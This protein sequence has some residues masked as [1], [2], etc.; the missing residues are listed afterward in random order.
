MLQIAFIPLWEGRGKEVI[1][2]RS[3][4]YGIYH[5]PLSKRKSME[6]LV[7]QGSR[8]QKWQFQKKITA[9]LWD[10]EKSLLID[11]T[12]SITGE[13]YRVFS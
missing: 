13:Y 9:I 4:T 10:S 3:K 6:W 8:E 2:S 1:E 12:L 5:D 7:Y 11:F